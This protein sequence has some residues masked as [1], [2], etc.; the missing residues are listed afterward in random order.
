MH[1][2]G[3]KLISLTFTDSRGLALV[4]K[5]ELLISTTAELYKVNAELFQVGAH[6]SAL[7]GLESFMLKLDGV[8]LD[9]NRKLRILHPLFDRLDNLIH[10]TGTVLQSA[11]VFICALVCGRRK[12]LREKV[13][14]GTVQ[15]YAIKTCSV[16]K[17]SCVSE[18]NCTDKINDQIQT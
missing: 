1:L 3:L 4:L 8:D 9:T 6:I 7:F 5:P 18:L 14:V 15:L 2:Y 11:A 17:F 16:R 13:S 10:N 12:E